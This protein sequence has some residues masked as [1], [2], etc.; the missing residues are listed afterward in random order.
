MNILP[1]NEQVKCEAIKLKLIFTRNI[2]LY[3]KN[4]N[5]PPNI[6]RHQ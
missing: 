4:I 3:E 2:L 6:L 1:N 5:N